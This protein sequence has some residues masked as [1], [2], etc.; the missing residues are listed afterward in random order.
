MGKEKNKKKREVCKY[1]DFGKAIK[2][3]FEREKNNPGNPSARAPLILEHFFATVKYD[4]T[5]NVIDDRKGEPS[6]HLIKSFI[7]CPYTLPLS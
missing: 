3:M 6:K 5:L 1:D 2:N 7:F 4:V